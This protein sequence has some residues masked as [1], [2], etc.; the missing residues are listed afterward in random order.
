[1]EPDL[2][3]KSSNNSS[4]STPSSSNASTSATIK[5]TDNNHMAVELADL[6]SKLRK[7]RQEL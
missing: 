6:K 3:L 7:Y 2:L 1:M 5:I 4:T